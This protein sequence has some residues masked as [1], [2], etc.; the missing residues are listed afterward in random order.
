[1]SSIPRLPPL[2]QAHHQPQAHLQGSQHPQLQASLHT[3]THTRQQQQQQQPYY[4]HEQQP[5]L[6]QP[7][8]QHPEQPPPQSHFNFQQAQHHNAHSPSQH[9]QPQYPSSAVS[10]A[11]ARRPL[12]SLPALPGTPVSVSPATTQWG[13]TR[14]TGQPG[15]THGHAAATGAP[16]DFG[17]IVGAAMQDLAFYKQECQRKVRQGQST[18]RRAGEERCDCVSVLV[19]VSRAYV[20]LCGVMAWYCECKCCM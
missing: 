16:N 18:P 13:G 10:V 7:Y 2:P 17:R 19:C 8:R 11:A 15:E 4:H 1:M 20:S 5:H 12:S 14:S 9:S 6:E 3:S